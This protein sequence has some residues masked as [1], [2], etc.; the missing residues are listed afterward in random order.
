[1]T[2]TSATLELKP[3]PVSVISVPGAPLRGDTEVRAGVERDENV[4][5]HCLLEQLEGMLFKETVTYQ[6]NVSGIIQHTNELSITKR[7]RKK[8]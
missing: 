7:S 8:A 6:K 2:F 1:M 3:L 4:K 5:E